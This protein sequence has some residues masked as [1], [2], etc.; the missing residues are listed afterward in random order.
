[1]MGALS[2]DIVGSA[3]QW[4]NIKSK[5]FEFIHDKCN[6]MDD[7]ILTVALADTILTGIFY[8]ENMRQY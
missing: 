7:S 1:M 8:T 5:E 6:F 2:G 4:H 3:F